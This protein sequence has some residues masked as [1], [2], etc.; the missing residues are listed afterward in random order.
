MTVLKNGKVGI[1]RTDPSYLLDVNDT[2]RVASFRMETG[3]TNGY[4]LKTDAS[5]NAT[6]QP[7]ITGIDYDWN[8]V[9]NNLMS[10]VPGFVGIRMYPSYPLDVNGPIRCQ[11]VYEIS[12]KR[13]KK[14][15]NTISSALEKVLKIRGANYEYKTNE[16]ADKGFSEGKN[17][18]FIAQELKEVLPELVKQDDE[19]YYSVNYS[20]V[21]PVL[22][23][24]IKEQQKEIAELKQLISQGTT[25]LNDNTLVNGNAKLYQNNPN[26]FNQQTEIS[27]YLADDVSNAAMLIFDMNG[28]QIKRYD[29]AAR[30]NDKVIIH[31]NELAPG[32]YMYSL[33]ADGKLVDTKRMVLTQ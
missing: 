7:D 27:Y 3:A 1:G 17:Y 29:I 20:G 18:G 30:G 16:F 12:D 28:K 32:M 25:G 31:G 24:A 5:G 10:A 11:Y 9:G 21:I 2:V 4:V 33:I 14:N 6:W 26:P 22:V 8:I 23:E 15:I 19:G 13:F